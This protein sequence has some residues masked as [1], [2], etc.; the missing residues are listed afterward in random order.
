MSEKQKIVIVSR[1]SISKDDS[2]SHDTQ[3]SFINNYIKN[4]INITYCTIETLSFNASAFN[5]NSKYNKEILQELNNSKN[6]IFIFNSIDRLSRNLNI[7]IEILNICDDNNHQL[8]FVREKLVYI[9]NSDKRLIINKIMDAE[10]ESQA[11]SNRQTELNL[12]RKRKMN[13]S[14]EEISVKKN[15]VSLFPSWKTF[16]YIL[17]DKLSK[18]DIN[19]IHASVIK[20]YMIRII[21]LCPSISSELKNKKISH[22]KNENIIFDNEYNEE[23]NFSQT[24]DE[25]VIFFVDYGISN[26]STKNEDPYY[27]N[28]MIN[29]INKK[30]EN[31]Y[32]LR[33]IKDNQT[34]EEI[35]IE[36]NLSEK[37]MNNIIELN[38]NTHIKL[39][40][41]R[42]LYIN[43]QFVLPD[44]IEIKH[45][46]YKKYYSSYSNKNNNISY[47]MEQF[48]SNIKKDE[49]YLQNVAYLTNSIETNIDISSII[50]N[51]S[52]NINTLNL[53]SIGS[54]PRLEEQEKQE[55]DPYEDEVIR[56]LLISSSDPI[57]VSNNQWQNQNES[58][59]N[60][61][62]EA[63]IK[64]LK[65]LLEQR[66]LEESIL[67]LELP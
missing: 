50:D 38:K 32:F 20:K 49:S 59:E 28:N 35:C 39:Q 6:I 46:K 23:L 16:T 17:I 64:L 27:T 54:T 41:N 36:N 62:K 45:E 18:A 21:E 12:S 30:L 57:H 29:E 25:I 58:Q 66:K 4:N 44:D 42:R 19:K 48:Y 15:K 40:P 51:L 14:G 61:D 11:M 56:S 43:T 22:I 55:E 1:L 60:K 3:Q 2:Q 7:A 65:N 34:I 8:H 33:S 52:S 24:Y 13:D 9:K 63:Q 10:A 37:D 26:F 67:R 53:N 31:P 47:L 5:K